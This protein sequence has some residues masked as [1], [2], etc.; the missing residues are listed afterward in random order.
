MMAALGGM[1]T[2]HRVGAARSCVRDRARSHV[3]ACARPSAGFGRN[4]RPLVLCQARPSKPQKVGS[5][6]SPGGVAP[7][8]L[9]QASAV[10]DPRQA[11]SIDEGD[12]YVGPRNRAAEPRAEDIAEPTR[13]PKRLTKGER[14]EIGEKYEWSAW[15]STCG[16]ISIAITA[17]Y[18]RL[19]REVSDGGAFPSS[20]LF[21]QLALIAGA[22][23]GMEFYARYAHKYL[24]HDSLWSMSM[25]DRKEWNR[26]I[27]LLHESHHLPREGAF[28]ANDIFAIANGVPAFALCAYG[29][30][31]PGVF[32]G[33]CFGAGLGITL[34]G[35]AYMY[36]H[37]GLV[38][39]RFPTGPLGKLPLLR[40]IAAGH[41]IHHTE[42]FDGVPWGLFLGIQELEQVPGGIAELEAV[43]E[44]SDRKM[45]REEEEEAAR[46]AACEGG[47]VEACEEVGFATILQPGEHIPSQAVAPACKL[48]EDA[49]GT[50]VE[51]SR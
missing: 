28:E 46:V 26:P 41:T 50:A 30:L 6:P 1:T 10:A 9:N 35:I 29:F 45:R 40:K 34:F 18:F 51:Q 38:H 27:W 8:H 7:K 23:V 20:E 49:L 21:A 4:A 16:V 14:E 43:M 32:G 17:T 37:D 15:V 36:V 11:R 24:W 33:L 13:K 2:A 42:A 44:A 39:K 12:P 47:D 25:K 48:P 5:S 19:L 22:A 31:T 3:R